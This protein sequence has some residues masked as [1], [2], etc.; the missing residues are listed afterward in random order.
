MA[1][2]TNPHVEQKLLICALQTRSP[3][4]RGEILSETV[5]DDYGTEYG[6]LVRKR[7]D[8]LLGLGKNLGSAEAFGED[9][10]LT[11]GAATWITGTE[12]M[13]NTAARFS[14]GE[15][16]AYIRTLKV[17]RNVR[18][19]YQAQQEINEL[20]GKELDEEGIEKI[21]SIMERS[22][23]GIR[24][25]FDRQPL[26]H[27][28]RRQS[29]EEAIK[30]LDDVL[31]FDPK[32]FISTGQLGLDKHLHGWE[33]GNLVTI[34]A[35][36]GGGKSTMAMTMGLNQFL[37]ANLNVCF[38]S[39]EM[40]KK[41]L[42]VRTLSNISKVPHGNIR[43][44][45]SLK[46][47]QRSEVTKAYQRFHRHGHNSNCTFTIWDVKEA[48][49]TPAKMEAALAPFM[50]D[51]IYV[52]YITLFHSD[53]MDTWKMQLEYSRYLKSMAKR[54]N[55]V[56][57][58][59]TQ[60]SD[61]ERVKYGRAIEENTDYWMWWRYR[62]DEEQ[63][64]GKGELRLDKARHTAKRRFQMEFFLDRMDIT[65]S[66]ADV[67][68]QNENKKEK[69]VKGVMSNESGAWSDSAESW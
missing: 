24:E 56:I 38:V 12:T 26:L 17:H 33:K 14:I 47:E 4:I 49:F 9:P 51:V 64:S 27:L 50:Y 29:K 57:V 13:R 1:K 7:I 6:V 42:M 37:E 63:E 58:V 34:S 48:A 40:T 45:K 3:R 43:Y 41:E 8:T 39:M 25:G 61:D 65:T 22:I 60:L 36:R 35:P 66:I 5:V 31:T 46:E 16:R 32:A 23:M 62:E 55:C 53:N 21:G 69:K 68:T 52:D 54:L 30:L 20:A 15:V 28:G 44:S 67:A 59:L 11:K 19:I 2:P 18:Q 10:A